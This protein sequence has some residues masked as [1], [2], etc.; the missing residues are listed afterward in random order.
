MHGPLTTYVKLQVADAP[1]MECRE[2]F[3]C[4]R[5]QRK[6]LVSDPGTH[7]GTI[8]NPRWQEKRS[9]HSRRMRN[10][11]FVWQEA[12]GCGN[13]W[14]RYFMITIYW[15]NLPVKQTWWILGNILHESIA[16][17]REPQKK[18]KKYHVYI[19]WSI[20]Y[21]VTKLYR[22]LTEI[23][24]ESSFEPIYINLLCLILL[25]RCPGFRGKNKRLPGMCFLST[26]YFW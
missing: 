26:I 1:G 18:R 3:P 14:F 19:S 20:W 21:N 5:L 8:V 17:R 9:R 10:P 16:T 6:P 22:S 13:L 11:Q 4:P 7:H 15:P 12:H 25:N 23:I 2:R 24:N